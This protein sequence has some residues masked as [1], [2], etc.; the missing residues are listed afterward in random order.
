MLRAAAIVVAS[1]AATAPAVAEENSGPNINVLRQASG[2]YEYR[3]LSDGRERGVEE[4]KLLVYRDGSRALMMW[5]DLWAKN[6][7]FTSIVRVAENFRPLTAFA[8]YWVANGYKGTTLFQVDGNRL[9]ATG[10]GL[11]GDVGHE[12]AVPERFSIG[13]HPVAGDGWHL[14][15]ASAVGESGELDMYSLEATADIAKPVLGRMIKMTYEIVGEAVVETPAGRFDTTHYR[16][17][18][19]TDLWVTGPDRILVRMVMEK[20]DREYVLTELRSSGY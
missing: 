18:G 6:A 20:F 10:T 5:H 14:W 12:I 7:Q 16:L 4:F 11:D 19:N 17:A 15:Y 1:L 13:T 3:A 9:R 2:H 8:S